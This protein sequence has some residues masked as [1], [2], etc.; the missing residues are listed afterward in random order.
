MSAFTRE[1]NDT[2]PLPKA[3]G[4]F[5][6]L[7]SFGLADLAFDRGGDQSIYGQTEVKSTMVFKRYPEGPHDTIS[8]NATGSGSADMRAI[9]LTKLFTMYEYRAA[10]NFSAP[11][12]DS[13]ASLGRTFSYPWTKILR[14]QRCANSQKIRSS[15]RSA[16]AG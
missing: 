16:H 10:A 2:S 5:G 13:L 14:P 3:W 1:K 4:A 9:R 8:Q 12:V 15:Y 6:H 11:R 7:E